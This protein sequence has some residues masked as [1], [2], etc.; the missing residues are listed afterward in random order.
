MA[1]ITKERR[2]QM[3]AVKANYW[4]NRTPEE[5][6]AIFAKRKRTVQLATLRAGNLRPSS[7]GPVGIDPDFDEGL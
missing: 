6:S 5:R 7:L 1:K 3:A 4:A 2:E